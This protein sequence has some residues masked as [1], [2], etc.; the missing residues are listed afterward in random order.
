MKLSNKVFDALKWIAQ[1]LLPALGTAYVGLAAIWH[2][3]FADEI[4]KT[5]MIVDLFLGTLLGISTI[6]YQTEQLNGAAATNVTHAPYATSGYIAPID[7]PQPT[8]GDITVTTVTT[9][10]STSH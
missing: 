5:I 4:V 6:Q 8:M 3:P 9:S 2:W 1:I 7:D 10:D